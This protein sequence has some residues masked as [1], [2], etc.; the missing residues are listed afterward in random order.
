MDCKTLAVR[1]FIIQKALRTML[2]LIY[3][4]HSVPIVSV[5]MPLGVNYMYSVF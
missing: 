4:P 2:Y 5:T 3:I 1:S